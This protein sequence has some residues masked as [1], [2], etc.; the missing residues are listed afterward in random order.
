MNI[1]KITCKYCQEEVEAVIEKK[2]FSNGTKHLSASCP[3]CKKWIKYLPQEKN[4]DMLYFGKY[5]GKRMSEVVL[6]D[7]DYL[8][9]LCEETK[10]ERTRKLIEKTFEDHWGKTH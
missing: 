9:W 2:I 7:P 4:N 3:V 8:Q 5:K 10:K 1:H 6:T